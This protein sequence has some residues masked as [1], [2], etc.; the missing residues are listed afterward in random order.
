M[1]R[2]TAIERA[3]ADAFKIAAEA[4]GVGAYLDNQEFV[5]KY[6]QSKG[7]GRGVRF[8]MYDKDRQRSQQYN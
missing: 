8:A 7:D 1:N 2:G 3:T 6:L 4:F 5:V